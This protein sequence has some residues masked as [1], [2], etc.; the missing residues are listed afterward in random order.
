M[1]KFS[2]PLRAAGCAF[3]LR[4]VAAQSDV[5][6]CASLRHQRRPSNAATPGFRYDRSYPNR[7]RAFLGGISGAQN[8]HIVRP[9]QPLPLRVS[10]RN[11]PAAKQFRSNWPKT[12]RCFWL[13]RRTETVANK[14][15][16]RRA[17]RVMSKELTTNERPMCHRRR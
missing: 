12:R 5:S 15:S 7:K 17:P 6:G 13:P 16:S 4:E 3:Q 1:K 9:R 10:R 8:H 14:R 11:S 2:G